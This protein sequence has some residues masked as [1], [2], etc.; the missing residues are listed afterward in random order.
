MGYPKSPLLRIVAVVLTAMVIVSTL[1]A[2]FWLRYSGKDKDAAE[3]SDRLDPVKLVGSDS[4][5][6]PEQTVKMLGVK[7]ATAEKSTQPRKLEL[8]GSLGLDTNL[9]AR[10]HT[11][12]AGEIMQITTIRDVSSTGETEFRPLDFGDKVEKNQ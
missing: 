8:A 1:G 6:L 12:F 11:R 9:L 10:V 2:A 7:V 4:L 3:G 5:E